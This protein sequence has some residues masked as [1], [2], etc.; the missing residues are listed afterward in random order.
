M[1]TVLLNF[2]PHTSFLSKLP[3]GFQGI[4]GDLL[5]PFLVQFICSGFQVVKEGHNRVCQRAFFLLSCTKARDNL[6]S[7]KRLWYIFPH[8]WNALFSET[9]N[10]ARSFVSSFDKGRR[11]RNPKQNANVA[12]YDLQCSSQCLQYNVYNAYNTMYVDKVAE[13]HLKV[14]QRQKMSVS[15]G[16]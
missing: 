13:K 15:G 4:C 12:T 11:F 16:G 14:T 6:L 10:C 8:R 7:D 9:K 3:L 2:L 1:P 5:S